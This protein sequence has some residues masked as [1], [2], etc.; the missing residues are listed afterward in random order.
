MASSKL[1]SVST[2]NSDL[3]RDSSICSLSTLI[4]DVEKHHPSLTMDDLLKNIYNDHPPPPPPDSSATAPG[5]TADEVWKEI[6]AGGGAEGGDQAAAE[7]E[8]DQAREGGGGGGGLAE[9]TL[10]DFLTRA[11]A[12][13]EEDVGVGAVVPIGYG[14]FQVQAAAP[15]QPQGQLVFGNNNGTTSGGGRGAKRRAVQE[16]PLDKATQQ[17]QRRMIK[18]RESA[19]RSRERKQAYT[20]ELESL[21]TQLEEENARLV[22]EEA[23]Q[24]K[25]RLKKDSKLIIAIRTLP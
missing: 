13:R 23:E 5:R 14:Q 12:V 8:A 9:M 16:A 3:P 11:G 6:V 2:A 7:G 10:E 19:A 25:E 22:R 4:A 18:N 15:P 17:K 1:V 20:V 24:K 21:V